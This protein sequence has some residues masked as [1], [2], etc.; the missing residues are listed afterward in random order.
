M[1]ENTSPYLC[2]Y[3]SMRW[4][5]VRLDAMT[6]SITFLIAF[7][8]VITTIYPETFGS[9]SAAAAG[10]ALSYSVQ[11]NILLKNISKIN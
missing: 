8:V 2:Y 11:V 9:T 3:S 7:L 1:D 4:L 5:A 10:L 6:T